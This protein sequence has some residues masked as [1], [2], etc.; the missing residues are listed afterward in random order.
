MLSDTAGD[1]EIVRPFLLFEVSFSSSTSAVLCLDYFRLSR[2]RCCV[3]IEVWAYDY[4]LLLMSAKVCR[5][6]NS[7]FSDSSP[8]L[9]TLDIL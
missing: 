9:K 3:L 1:G 7:F 8:K 5:L 4:Y 6:F 2:V